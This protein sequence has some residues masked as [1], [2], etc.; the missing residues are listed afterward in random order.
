VVWGWIVYGQ[1]LVRLALKYLNNPFVPSIFREN[2]MTEQARGVSVNDLYGGHFLTQE[3][4]EPS[5]AIQYRQLTA[6][7]DERVKR[8]GVMNE[9]AR[10]LHA[11]FVDLVGK[12][13]GR[14]EAVK[15]LRELADAGH[16]ESK[17]LKHAPVDRP[18]QT[19]RIF[20]GSAGA[21]VPPPFHHL[22]WN[23]V[24]GVP[25]T[26][27]QTAD[28]NT[29]DMNMHMWA[30]EK[31]SAVASYCGLGIY[32][33]PMVA[34]GYLT[35]SAAPELSYFWGDWCTDDRTTTQGWIKLNVN[36]YDLAGGFAGTVYEN[37]YQLWYDSSWFG[38]GAGGHLVLNTAY[39]LVSPLIEVDNAHSYLIWVV[40][41][42]YIYGGGWGLFTYPGW[43]SEAGVNFG[44]H[45]PWIRWEL[46]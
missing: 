45:V 11:P 8:E 24:V 44:A 4:I 21:Y 32:F 25:D 35:V 28:G 23:G 5:L 22:V 2:L 37:T 6:E 19:E 41:G 36:S 9:H 27:D 20:L 26:N 39:P 46:N 3:Q 1:R 33:Y 30:N 7:F 31:A 43:S 12:D 16:R 14:I 38:P 40:I 10:K 13:P 15:G 18:K 42:G 29:G 17:T 34:N